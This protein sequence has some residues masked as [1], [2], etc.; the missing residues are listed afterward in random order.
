MSETNPAAL[1]AVLVRPPR[2]ASVLP[3]EIYETPFL[4]C[5]WLNSVWVVEPP[6]SSMSASR[7]LD[8][9]RWPFSTRRFQAVAVSS[10]FRTILV[11]RF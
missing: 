2:A 1:R 9:P 4:D 10:A 6:P 5:D 8:R 7:L 3:D 11:T